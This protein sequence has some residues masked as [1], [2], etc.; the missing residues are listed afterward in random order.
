MFQVVTILLHYKISVSLRFCGEFSNVVNFGAP[1]GS[2]SHFISPVKD[3][4]LLQRLSKLQGH[5]QICKENNDVTEQ[6]L[7]MSWLPRG[8]GGKC[9]GSQKEGT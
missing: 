7:A 6:L 1:C 2:Y 9:F 5:V 8:P 3:V 4:F